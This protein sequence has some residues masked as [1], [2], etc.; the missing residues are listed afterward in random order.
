MMKL[1]LQQQGTTEYGL[2]YPKDDDFTLC[3][4]TYADWARD[5]DDW[6]RTSG[7]AFFLGMK[8][9]SCINKKQSCTSLSI[10]E[11]GYVVDA[12]NC[13]QIL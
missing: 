3:A 11:A 5:I 8:L 7:G 2:W 6:K 4:Y 10:V 9:I 1:L 13:T 12:T